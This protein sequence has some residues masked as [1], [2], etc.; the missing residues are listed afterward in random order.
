MKIAFIIK[1]IGKG[2]II[3]FALIALGKTGKVDNSW[4][5]VACLMY[6]AGSVVYQRDKKC[7]PNKPKKQL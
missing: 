2:M 4:Y 7:K 6:C 5:W 3:V 1:Y